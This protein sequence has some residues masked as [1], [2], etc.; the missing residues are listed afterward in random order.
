MTC[1]S[2]QMRA[3]G[4]GNLVAS[5][6]AIHLRFNPVNAGRFKHEAGQVTREPAGV[7]KG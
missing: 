4:A 5:F 2:S 6:C 7:L 1:A 3:R